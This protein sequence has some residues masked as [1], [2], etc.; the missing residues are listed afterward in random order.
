MFSQHPVTFS[1]D[2][3][4]IRYVLGRL[5]GRALEWAEAFN[6][7]CNLNELSYEEFVSHFHNVFDHPNLGGDAAHCL[8]NLRQG[9]RSVSDYSVDFWTLSCHTKWNEEALKSVFM[10]GLSERVKD[11]LATHEL[12]EDLKLLV[13]LSIRIDN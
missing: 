1:S 6:S 13:G 5:R 2:I 12:P 4:K 8:L 9:G 3:T 11:E 7:N 10:K